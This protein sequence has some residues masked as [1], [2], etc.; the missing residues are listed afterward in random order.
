MPSSGAGSRSA[1]SREHREPLARDLT[2]L[3]RVRERV[4][5]RERGEVRPARPHCS[6]IVPPLRG[7]ASDLR[8]S[9]SPYRRPR[10]PHLHRRT[11]AGRRRRRSGRSCSAA[12]RNSTPGDAAPGTPIPRASGPTWNSRIPRV[13]AVRREP[14][15]VGADEQHARARRRARRT[16]RSRS[17]A[18]CR[19]VIDA[20]AEVERHA[21][22]HE[23][24]RRGRALHAVDRP[25]ALLR[26]EHRLVA[27]STAAFAL[28]NRRQSSKKHSTFAPQRHER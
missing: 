4:H 6:S 22:E 14:V 20:V 21:R 1:I 12:L 25:R 15:L 19:P 7:R 26:A 11:S 10:H 17:V 27:S 2:A 13:V 9:A 23:L 8:R 24:E 3:V 5:A 16:A 28:R 18:K